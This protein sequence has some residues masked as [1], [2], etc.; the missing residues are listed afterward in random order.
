MIPD[1][2][3]F[4]SNMINLIFDN[5]RGGFTLDPFLGSGII[6]PPPETSSHIWGLKSK[7]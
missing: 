7:T 6:Q 1:P 4:R 5:L 3:P 2:P